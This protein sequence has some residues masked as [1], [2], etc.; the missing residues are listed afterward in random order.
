MCIR[1]RVEGSKCEHCL[2][3]WSSALHFGQLPARSVS[4]GKVVA[5][6]KH[7]EAATCCT[8]RGR[9]GPV[10]SKGGRGPCGLDRSSRKLLLSPESMYPFCLYLRSLSMGKVTPYLWGKKTLPTHDQN[11]SRRPSKCRPLPRGRKTDPA[12]TVG[13]WDYQ[14]GLTGVPKVQQ[15]TGRNPPPLQIHMYHGTDM[16]CTPVLQL[17]TRPNSISS[18]TSRAGSGDRHNDWGSPARRSRAVRCVPA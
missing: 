6:L 12:T 14:R 7:R 16:V 3:Q 17:P 1:D 9:R 2:Q 15:T 10:T 5:Q 11:S 13:S 18:R 8:S 4:G